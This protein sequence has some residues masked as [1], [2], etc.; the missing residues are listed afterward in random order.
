MKT[1]Q[2]KIRKNYR[3]YAQISG[4]QGI[5]RRSDKWKKVPAAVL[6]TGLVVTAAVT[7]VARVADRVVG[8][9]ITGSTI[10]ETRGLKSLTILTKISSALR[11]TGPCGQ[12]V[13]LQ[14]FCLWQLL[15]LTTCSL[16]C[17]EAQLRTKIWNL[18][19]CDRSLQYCAFK[20]TLW[21][22]IIFRDTHTH[23]KN[24]A[25][26][27]VTENSLIPFF[28]AGCFSAGCCVKNRKICHKCTFTCTCNRCVV[29]S[30]I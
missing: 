29:S 18:I 6:A 30:K 19:Y 27:N 7:V 10:K 2:K 3:T 23:K 15:M 20:W 13:Y 21:I 5:L 14:Q 8:A 1:K 16:L 26:T 22:W 12:S 9:L 17:L 28:G 4:D 11:H 24:K 25:Q